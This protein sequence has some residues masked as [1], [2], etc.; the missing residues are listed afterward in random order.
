MEFGVARRWLVDNNVTRALEI[1]SLSVTGE[2]TFAYDSKQ[3]HL[4]SRKLL[5]T[6]NTLIFPSTLRLTVHFLEISTKVPQFIKYAKSAQHYFCDNVQPNC[7]WLVCTLETRNWSAK[8]S[9]LVTRTWSTNN[10]LRRNR[11]GDNSL[12]RENVMWIIWFTWQ[13]QPLLRPGQQSV[14]QFCVYS[15]KFSGL[16]FNGFFQGIVD[17]KLVCKTFDKV[18]Y[19]NDFS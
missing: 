15:L 5:V 10:I 4:S 16:L 18:Q 19:I 7:R 13:A 9:F 2:V 8:G 1:S 14:A 11:S 6:F 12:G 17:S 3:P